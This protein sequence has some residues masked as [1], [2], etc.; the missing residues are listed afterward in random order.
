MSQQVFQWAPASLQ[1]IFKTTTK[2]TKMAAKLLP[3]YSNES[4][5]F[6]PSPIELLFYLSLVY[7]HEN[8]D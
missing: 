7:T 2:D 5:E 4:A 3:S 1:P 6:I 8:C